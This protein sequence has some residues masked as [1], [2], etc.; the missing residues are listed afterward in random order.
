MTKDGPKKGYL[1]IVESFLRRN[2]KAMDIL[3]KQ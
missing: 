2:K 1:T 3:S